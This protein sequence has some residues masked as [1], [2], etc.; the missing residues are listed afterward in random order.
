MGA[1]KG[2][3]WEREFAVNLSLW[4][5]EGTADDW[6]WRVLGSGGRATNRAKRGKSTAGGYG[7]ICATDHR[8]QGLLDL[9]CFELKRGYNS[10][11]MQDLFDKPKGPNTFDDFL[12]QV[13][14]A[15]SLAGTPYWFL[16]HK[17]DR[18]EAMVWTNV[19]IQTYAEK[20]V[21]FYHYHGYV[22]GIT[23]DIFFTDSMRKWLKERVNEYRS[24]RVSSDA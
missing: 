10:V 22:W 20:Y 19:G 24:E 18:R 7:D 17:R 4:W 13:R 14:S 8:G 12:V 15:A 23:L 9:C 2:S 3:A 16:I 21:S 5:S 11:S 1:S 6:F